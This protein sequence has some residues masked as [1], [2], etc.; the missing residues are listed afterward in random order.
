M[1]KPVRKLPKPPGV[2]PTSLIRR[3]AISPRISPGYHPRAGFGVD[4][5]K[6]LSHFCQTSTMTARLGATANPLADARGSDRSPERKGGVALNSTISHGW[7][8]RF[9]RHGRNPKLLRHTPGAPGSPTQHLFG[10]TGAGAP[11][12]HR[13]GESADSRRD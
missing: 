3:S 13:H 2:P 4:R 10:G 9:Y 12:T 8:P 1:A 7:R 6:R 11:G 5:R